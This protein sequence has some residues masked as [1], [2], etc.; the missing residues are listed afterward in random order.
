MSRCV[1]CVVQS[2]VLCPLHAA[3]PALLAAAKRASMVYGYKIGASV[4][5]DW[6]QELSDV[7]KAIANAEG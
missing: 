3:A 4:A 7:L 6:E 1:A 2:T 5:I